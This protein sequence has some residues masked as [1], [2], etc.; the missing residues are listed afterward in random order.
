MVSN[1]KHYEFGEIF[2]KFGNDSLF[3]I[4]CFSGLYFSMPHIFAVVFPKHH[5]ALADKKRSDFN[6]YVCSSFHHI[7]VVPM[8]IYRMYALSCSDC[9]LVYFPF[10]TTLI[11]AVNEQS[12]ALLHCECAPFSVG[13]MVADTLFY[14]IPEAYRN[15]KYEYLLHHV[16][17]LVLFWVVPLVTSDVSHFCGRILIMESTSIFFTL[18][19]ML[20]N[21]G[22]SNSIFVSIFE[23]AFAVDFFLVRILNFF[24]IMYNVVMTLIIQDGDVDA[25]KRTTGWIIFTVFVPIVLL[26]M[27]WFAIISKKSFERFVVKKKE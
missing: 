7:V 9:A 18:A 5:A 10:S 8:A 4:L 19:Y 14:A 21:T 27:Y 2:P 26:Q 23:I 17:G 1:I 3:W 15:G 16:L 12:K 20:R 11:E 6:S 24:D 25:E 22:H 13:Y